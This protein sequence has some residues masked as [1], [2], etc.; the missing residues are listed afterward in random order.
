[1]GNENYYQSLAEKILSSGVSESEVVKFAKY[2]DGKSWRDLVEVI[3]G[4]K[5][6]TAERNIKFLLASEIEKVVEIDTNE[7]LGDYEKRL[8][9]K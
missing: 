8:K 1:M 7:S 4:I 9:P 6:Q 3:H 5:K 2:R